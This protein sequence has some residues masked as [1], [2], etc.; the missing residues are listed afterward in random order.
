MKTKNCRKKHS[1]KT[2]GQNG[3]RAEQISTTLNKLIDKGLHQEDRKRRL[4]V[5][6]T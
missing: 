3:S 6:F 2:N 4:N 1:A 5:Q